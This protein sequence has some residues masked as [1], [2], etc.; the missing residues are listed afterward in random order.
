MFLEVFAQGLGPGTK[1]IPA[2]DSYARLREPA[3]GALHGRYI[4]LMNA[5]ALQSLTSMLGAT[6]CAFALSAFPSR[7]ETFRPVALP[8]TYAVAEAPGVMLF[9]NQDE[10]VVLIGNREP[11]NWLFSGPPSSFHIDRCRAASFSC[12]LVADFKPIVVGKMIAGQRNVFSELG[13][14]VVRSPTGPGVCDTFRTTSASARP[15]GDWSQKVVFCE[16]LGIVQITLSQGGVETNRLDLKSRDGL[17]SSG[18]FRLGP[19]VVIVGDSAPEVPIA[20]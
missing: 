9:M 20:K 8:I 3:C 7:S 5:K 2:P 15:Q 18:S 11:G 12:L 6:A 4:R 10:G 17:L 19:A 1:L 16:G 14:A 13:V